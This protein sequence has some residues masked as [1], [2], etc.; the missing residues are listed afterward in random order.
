M[1]VHG[2]FSREMDLCM[3]VMAAGFTAYWILPA[4]TKDR[5]VAAYRS[6]SFARGIGKVIHMYFSIQK[7]GLAGTYSEIV[8]PLIGGFRRCWCFHPQAALL[9]SIL[10]HPFINIHIVFFVCGVDGPGPRIMFV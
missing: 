5:L 4:A 10:K 9:F 8:R 7:A 1:A 6:E 2:G 3:P